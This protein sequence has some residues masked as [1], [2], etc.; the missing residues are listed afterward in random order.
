[1]SKN[2]RPSITE[3]F[4]ERMTEHSHVVRCEDISTNDFV[5]YR[6]YRD[7]GFPSVVVY[8]SDAYEF[9]DAEFLARPQNPKLDY[10]LLVGYGASGH[11]AR[12]KVGIGNMKGLMGALTSRNVWEYVPPEDR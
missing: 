3:Y 5:I 2:I 8:L 7:R 11:Y 6:I 12:K 10:I 1:M 4:R 9:T